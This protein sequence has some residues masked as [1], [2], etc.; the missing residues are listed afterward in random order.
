M[1]GSQI[2]SRSFLL[3]KSLAFLPA[4]SASAIP[5]VSRPNL[6]LKG[7]EKERKQSCYVGTEQHI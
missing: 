1:L 6:C 5:S 3:W 2:S 4:F 7:Q